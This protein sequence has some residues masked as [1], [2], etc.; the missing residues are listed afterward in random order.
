MQRGRDEIRIVAGDADCVP[1]IAKLQNRGF[2]CVVVFWDHAS[3]ELQ[4]AAS[5][6]VSLDPRLDDL[7]REG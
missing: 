7:R 4:D 2:P 1:V 6:F 3:R 5:E